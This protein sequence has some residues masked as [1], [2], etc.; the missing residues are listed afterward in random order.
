MFT[1]PPRISAAGVFSDYTADFGIGYGGNA[2][3][4]SAARTTMSQLR[5]D[6]RYNARPYTGTFVAPMAT[7][8]AG[9]ASAGRADSAPGATV[10]RSPTDTDHG[11]YLTEIGGGLQGLMGIEAFTHVNATTLVAGQDFPNAYFGGFDMVAA[12]L[13]P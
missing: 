10:A 3:F 7:P 4:D 5:N 2:S 13:R 12:T 11:R 6:S 8:S 9:K 1:S